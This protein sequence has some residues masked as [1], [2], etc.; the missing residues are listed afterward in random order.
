MYVNGKPGERIAIPN[1]R[2][3]A[4]YTLK[5]EEDVIL[6]FADKVYEEEE[7][8]KLFPTAKVGG[9]WEKFVIL[10][11]DDPTNK[12][13][14]VRFVTIDASPPHFVNG[15]FRFINFTDSGVA[16]KLGDKTI[17]IPPK[18]T[19]TFRDF[20]EHNTDFRM[21][22][23]EFRPD[24]D[25]KLKGRPFINKLLRYNKNYRTMFF[26]YSPEGSSRLTYQAAE[27]RGL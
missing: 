12:A 10:A 17:K 26:V 20:A 15:D 24:K 23:N 7:Q 27:I 4:N 3:S 25:K 8:I 5:A 11:F 19:E 1:N 9:T 2:F 6:S 21:K 18:S 14:P 22:I 16:G 13:F